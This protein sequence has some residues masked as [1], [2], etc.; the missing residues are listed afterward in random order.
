MV[1]PSTQSEE[2]RGS[3]LIIGIPVPFILFLI[4]FLGLHD[5]L[6]TEKNLTGLVQTI[7]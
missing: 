4:P 1:P 5:S 6:Y 3:I 2:V 7:S